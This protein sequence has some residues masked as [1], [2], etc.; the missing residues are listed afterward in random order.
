MICPAGTYRSLKDVQCQ[1]CPAGTNTDIPG[2]FVCSKYSDPN[3]KIHRGV[4]VSLNVLKIS[5]FRS[6]FKTPK[7]YFVFNTGLS[8]E[9][10]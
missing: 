6:C 2:R 3:N 7:T 5:L 8:V 10:H 1:Q 4:S 9:K